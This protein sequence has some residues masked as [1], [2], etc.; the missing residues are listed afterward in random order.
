MKH[1]SNGT[2]SDSDS[3]NIFNFNDIVS[4]PRLHDLVDSRTAELLISDVSDMESNYGSGSWEF[5]QFL[6]DM[7]RK[8]PGMISVPR[9]SES[10][11][12]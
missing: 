11:V 3:G 12:I 9:F 6:E 7:T 2:S 10:E 8:L 4:G 1:S 5:K